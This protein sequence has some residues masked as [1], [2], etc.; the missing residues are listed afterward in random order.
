MNVV[1]KIRCGEGPVWSRLKGIART[2]LQFHMPV[3]GPTRWLFRAF[4]G[5]HVGM[6]EMRNWLVRFAWSEPLFRSQCES[7]GPGF[8]LE[9]LP[10]MVGH[11]RI[12]LG[13]HV[14][15]G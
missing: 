12:R 5:L 2:L 4:Y 7:I 6:R 3:V 13:D 14:E 8:R 15:L 11:G 10:Y 9:R 1:A